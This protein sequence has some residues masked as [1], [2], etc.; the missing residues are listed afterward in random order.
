[1]SFCFPYRLVW[2]QLNFQISCQNI[3]TISILH[4]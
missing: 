3:L 2:Q 4:G 1:M